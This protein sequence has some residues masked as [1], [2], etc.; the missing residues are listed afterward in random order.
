MYFKND[1]IDNLLFSEHNINLMH[2]K[3]LSRLIDHLDMEI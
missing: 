3:W 2:G 1:L